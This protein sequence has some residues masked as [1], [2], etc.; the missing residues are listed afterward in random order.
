LP[1]STTVSKVTLRDAGAR[2][3]LVDAVISADSDDVL[4]ITQR[5]GPIRPA[6]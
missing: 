2:H 3:D 5:A 1:S 4:Q 6:L